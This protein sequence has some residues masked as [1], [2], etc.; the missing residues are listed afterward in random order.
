MLK[1]LGKRAM[2]AGKRGKGKG[3]LYCPCYD[4]IDQQSQQNHNTLEYSYAPGK[5]G[6]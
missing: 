2:L 4:H 6:T 5:E 1:Y 3:I